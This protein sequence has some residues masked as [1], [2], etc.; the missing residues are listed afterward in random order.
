MAFNL[1]ALLPQLLP[2]AVQWG[3]EQETSILRQ[4]RPLDSTG[5][6]LAQ[7]VGV[8][9][10]DLIRVQHVFAIPWPED[11]YLRRAATDAGLLGPGVQGLT[12][13]HGIYIVGRRGDRRLISHE[14]RH[15]HQYEEAG[16]I[17]AFLREY[18]RQ[19][20][21]VGYEQAPLEI[22]ARDW[23]QV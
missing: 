13:G 1:A 18:L 21:D 7:A 19:I 8:K 10:P 11:P 14:C 17:G 5:L 22:D 6:L 9:K 12:L 16:S 3:E 4:G 20:I 2:K 15:V 23:E